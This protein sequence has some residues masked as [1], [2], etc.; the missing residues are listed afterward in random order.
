MV[1]REPDPNC[2]F[3]VVTTVY[4]TVILRTRAVYELI[5]DVGYQLIYDESE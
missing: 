1:F 5:A 3:I 4:L 2:G